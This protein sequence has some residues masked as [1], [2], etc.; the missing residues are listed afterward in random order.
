MQNH[1]LA[2]GLKYIH[3]AANG[4]GAFLLQTESKLQN[5]ASPTIVIRHVKTELALSNERTMRRYAISIVV[6]FAVK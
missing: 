3:P 6:S 1:V 5:I 4:D 2:L